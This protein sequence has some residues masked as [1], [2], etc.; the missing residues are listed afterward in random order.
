L[1]IQL[2][3]ASQVY[4]LPGIHTDPFDR[5]LIGQN[6]LEEIPLLTSDLQIAKYD[7]NAIW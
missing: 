3:H 1:P 7:V 6:Q 2:S 5:L 4:R